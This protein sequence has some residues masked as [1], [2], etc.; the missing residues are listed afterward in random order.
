MK[1]NIGLCLVGVVIGEFIGA[2]CG[3]GYLIIYGS[4]DLQADMG[5][6]VDRDPVCHR[7]GAVCNAGSHREIYTEKIKRKGD[8]QGLLFI[9]ILQTVS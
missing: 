8:L 3:L 5:A 1:V 7:H 9:L 2:R 6:D 4:P